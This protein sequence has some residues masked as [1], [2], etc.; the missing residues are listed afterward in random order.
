M[1]AR[2]PAFKGAI[3]EVG[4]VLMPVREPFPNV[5]ASQKKITDVRF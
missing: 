1:A 4:I 5:T 2:K 3:R